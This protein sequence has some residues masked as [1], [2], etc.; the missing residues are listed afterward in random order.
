MAVLLAGPTLVAFFSGGFFAEARLWT[1]LGVWILVAASALVAPRPLPT[2]RLARIAIGALAALT[3]WTLVSMLWAPL[4]GPAY[5]DAQRLLLYTGG[6]LAATS[7]LAES[8]AARWVEPALVAG[9]FVQT[10]FALSERLLPDVFELTATASAMGRIEQPLTYWNAQGSVLAIGLVLAIRLAG[11]PERPRWLRS[12]AMAA[13]PWLAT[14][15]YLALSRGALAALAAGV[16]ALLLI[17]RSRAQARVAAIVLGAGALAALAAGSI[18]GIQANDAGAGDGAAMLLVLLALSAGSVLASAK[19]VAPARVAALAGVA[20]ALLLVAAALVG[21]ADTTTARSGS[22]GAERL[23]SAGSNRYE[24]WRVALQMVA[25]API[26]GEGSGSFRVAW[27]RDRD[28]P[29]RVRD[30]HA[31]ALETTAELGVM[32]LA[33]LA[34]LFVAVGLAAARAVRASPVLGPG[35]AAGLV[36]WALHAQLDWISEM[37]ASSLNALLLAGLVLAL[38]GSPAGERAPRAPRRP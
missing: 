21:T 27:L 35:A 10:L 33:L 16:I 29:E 1:A 31:L 7:L 23:R 34:A 2:G 32:G 19:L 20:L 28:I 30:A 12:G 37:P 13:S 8:G 4:A 22:A 18:G 25:D 24:Y 6:L 17:T 14:A 36:A 11:T 38:A 15:L 26:R 9:A 5:A 3:V